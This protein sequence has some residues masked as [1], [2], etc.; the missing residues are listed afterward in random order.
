MQGS[1]A[2]LLTPK[3]H[4]LSCQHGGVRRRF[5]SICL[6]LHP[7]GNT[8]D[9]F[10]ATGITQDVSLFETNKCSWCIPHH[11]TLT[12]LRSV[13]WTKV[14]LNEANIRATP[15]TSSPWEGQNAKV[16]TGGR[17]KRRG[18]TILTVSNLRPQRYVLGSC[19]FDLLFGRHVD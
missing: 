14:S 5:V 2:Q 13:T 17:R 19:A 18:R 11:L 9:G 7:S 15:K 1:D 16:V 10:A 12:N 4:I 6:D 8:G 3:S